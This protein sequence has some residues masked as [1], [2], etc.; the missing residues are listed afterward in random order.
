MDSKSVQRLP[1]YWGLYFD[2]S[3]GMTYYP[4]GETTSWTFERATWSGP[5]GLHFAWPFLNPLGFA[6][7]ESATRLLAI[8]ERW[9]REYP[10]LRLELDDKA[11]DLGPFTR[12]VERQIIV[13]ASSERSETFSCGLMI[14]SIIRNGDA[15]ARES[16]LWE[17]HT[18]RLISQV[19]R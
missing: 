15:R 10:Q 6:T 18:A 5:F 14:N 16:W 1:E 8:C 3:T 2:P 9:L 13:H 17:L 11:R 4:N 12:T 7:E 19:L